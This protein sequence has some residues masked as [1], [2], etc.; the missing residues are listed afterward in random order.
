[1]AV[2]L[3]AA[4][5]K[6]IGLQGLRRIFQKKGIGGVLSILGRRSGTTGRRIK[7]GVRK[8]GSYPEGREQEIAQF[9]RGRGFGAIRKGRAFTTG[10]KGLGAYGLYRGGAAMVLDPTRQEEDADA[11]AAFLAEMSEN[12]PRRAALLQ[13]QQQVD[14]LTREV[15]EAELMSP[16]NDL[17]RAADLRGEAVDNEIALLAETLLR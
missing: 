8:I 11:L 12:D 16:I 3:I 13:M 14:S 5:A 7:K 10:V 1:M 4:G 17:Q 15:T 9:V 6:F 2:P